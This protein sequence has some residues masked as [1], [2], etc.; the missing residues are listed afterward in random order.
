MQITH[1]LGT[2]MPRFQSL[3]SGLTN[4]QARYRMEPEAWTALEIIN[5][6]ADEERFDFRVR[7]AY[8]LERPGEE[9]PPI[10]PEGWVSERRYNERDLTESLQDF[11][12]ERQKSLEWLKGLGEPDWNAEY[13][14]PWGVIRAGDIFVAWAA[15][16]LIH[17]RDLTVRLWALLERAAEPY[18]TRYAGEW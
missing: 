17:L 15:H 9:P 3:V 13:R 16:D 10:N 7:I 18:S 2:N 4:E 5:H 8:I 1:L 6:L 11:L 14:A 12:F